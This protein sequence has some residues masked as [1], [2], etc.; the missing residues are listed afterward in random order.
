M[1]NN[2]KKPAVQKL[3]EIKFRRNFNLNL[4][5]V[6]FFTICLFCSSAG[7]SC[8]GQSEKAGQYLKIDYPASTVRGEL[9][10]SVTYTLWI[11]DGVKTIRGIIVH[12]HGAGTTA[13]KEGSTAAYDLHWQMLARKWDCALLGPSYHVLNEKIDLTPGGSE[14]WFDPRLGSEKTF[15]SALSGFAQQSNHPEIEKVPWILWGHS[16][17]GIWA[18]VLSTM[19]PERVVAIWMRSGSAYMFRTKS[20]FPQPEVPSAVYDIPSMCN[21]GVKEKKNLPWIGTLATFQEYRAKGAPIGFAPDPLTGHECG[22][23]RYLAI[24]FL[25][26]CMAM[27]LP[28]KGSKNQTLKPVGKSKGWLAPLYGDSAVAFAD[29]KGNPSEAVW[30][31]DESVAKAWKDYVRTGSTSDYTAP[32]APYNVKVVK[33]GDN[34]NEITWNADP[35]FESGIRCFLI[36]RDGSQIARVPMRANGKFGRALYQGMTYHDTPDQPMPE[37]KYTDTSVKPGE[38]HTYTVINVNSVGLTSPLSDGTQPLPWQREMAL[39]EA[40][41]TVVVESTLNPTNPEN[42]NMS[43]NNL[44]MHTTLWGPAD[45]ITISLTKNNVWDRRLHEYH[46]PT[47]KEIIDGAYAPVNKNYVGVKGNSLRPVDLG[48]LVKEGGSSDPY[49]EPVRYAFPCLKPVGQII[50]G[51]DPLAGATPPKITQNCSNGLTS[52]TVVKDTVRANLEYVLGMTSN[53]YAIRGRLSGIKS[54]VFFRLYRHRDRSHETYMTPDGKFYTIPEARADSAV[55]KPFDP[56]ASGVDGRY[57]W[58]RQRMPAEKTFPKGFEYVVMGVLSIRGTINIESVQ[59]KTGL[60]TPV[61]NQPLNREWKGAQRPAIATSPGAAATASFTTGAD[62]R[63]LAF[64]TIVTTQDGDDLLALAKK[65]L[66]EAE[67]KGFEGVVQENTRWWNDFYDLREN[68]RVFRNNTG[69]NASDDILSIYRSW[70]DS[71]GGGTKTDMRQYECS[72][73]Y[74]Y[75]ERDFQEWDSSPCYNE[76]FTTSRFVRNWGDSQDMWKQIIEHWMPGAKDNARAMFGMPGMFITHGY[77]PP[78]KPDKYV[79]TTITL[80]LCLGTMAQIVRP[81]WDEWDY[82]GDTSFLRKECYPIM[83][84][85]ALFYAAYAKKGSDGYYHVIPSMEEERWGIYPEFSRNKDVISSL[86]MFR[87]GLTRAAAAAEFLGIDQQLSKEWRKEASLIVPYPTWK[88]PEGVIFAGMPD[89]EPMHLPGDHFGDAASYPTLLADEIN[90]DSPE[91]Q[92]AMMIRTVK[93]LPSGSTN[94]TLLLLGIM[95][96]PAISRRGISGA[97][98]VPD[99]ETLLNSRSGRI[100]LFPLTAPAAEIAF[101]NFQA[102][103]GF[104]VSACRNAKGVYYLEVQPRRNNKCYIMNPWAGKKVLVHEAGN[105]NPVPVTIDKS[106]GEYLI[107][108]AKA[109]HKYFIESM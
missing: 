70:Y 60:G 44:K 93:T 42:Q 2:I 6:I 63:M 19:H 29:Y 95:P 104:L 57:F 88:K 58:I 75:P 98:S 47:L 10:I 30:L 86:T 12:Q 74:A 26:A 96:D 31:P 23:S 40:A 81:A 77:L 56:P 83:K 15:L 67:A 90:L 8:F 85:M 17:G 3:N 100:H 107:F 94:G 18:D 49:R 73:S 9:Q 99:P 87:W 80:E 92:K 55:N 101:H 105:R 59:E 84:E 20:E 82:G 109:N 41:K 51:I 45:R 102:S 34:E 91:E 53:I 61:P 28:D 71:H 1:R 108:D 5:V 68:G 72:A 39:S 32:S 97:N 4:I 48:W 89:V 33:K 36:L 106:N 62:G 54:P 38:Q 43:I 25:D 37:M 76:I 35:D 27:R 103:G 14:W 11:P 13:S 52:F 65:R 7:T 16:G 22:D 64:V 50:I 79:H 24:P 78:V 69:N 66:T 46:I 21:P